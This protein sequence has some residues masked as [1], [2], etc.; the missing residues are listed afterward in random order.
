MMKDG[1][2]P[3]RLFPNAAL[4]RAA[5]P[6]ALAV[7]KLAAQP[8]A[9]RQ[10]PAQAQMRITV[11]AIENIRQ[12]LR[13]TPARKQTKSSPRTPVETRRVALRGLSNVTPSPSGAKPSCNTR[14]PP[15]QGTSA[16]R[17]AARVAAT[18]YVDQTEFLKRALL[19]KF[20][21]SQCVP[22]T[23][24]ADDDFE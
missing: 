15:A 23:P 18:P 19:Q 16:R 11:D 2:D 10:Q 12:G 13:K 7:P 5:R 14:S 9:A 4:E 1:V 8:A 17:S 6:L 24:E 21:G 20:K 3:G 22:A